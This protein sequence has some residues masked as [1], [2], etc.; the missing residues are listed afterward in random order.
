MIAG[1][2]CGSISDDADRWLFSLCRNLYARIAFSRMLPSR[3]ISIETLDMRNEAVGNELS[4]SAS[5]LLEASER[6]KSML[7]WHL[8]AHSRLRE[9]GC[10]KRGR[11]QTLGKWYPWPFLD[12]REFE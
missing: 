10:A 11:L 6:E 5:A 1:K 3:S 12:R 7:L 2:I 4:V 9:A 8:Q